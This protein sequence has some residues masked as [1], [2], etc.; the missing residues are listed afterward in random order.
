MENDTWFAPASTQI[1]EASAS[2]ALNCSVSTSFLVTVN[3]LPE[4]TLSWINGQIVAGSAAQWQWYFN[5]EIMEGANMQQIIPN[6]DGNYQCYLTGTNGCSVLSQA[7]DIVSTKEL[8]S[9]AVLI[10][11][12]PAKERATLQ[13][14]KAAN[15]MVTI[16]SA[17][18]K[19]MDQFRMNSSI[20]ELDLR[21]WSSGIYF[22]H[23]ASDESAP[24]D[25]K[26]IKE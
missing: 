24:L 4:N 7:I 12:N 22:I 11:P 26:L 17:D 16:Y 25:F 21:K 6:A 20:K 1:L 2:N 23:I 15:Q 5:G 9:Q 14:D 8:N 3:P 19:Q 10:M 13:M 18:G